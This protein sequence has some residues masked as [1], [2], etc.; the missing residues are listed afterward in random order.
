MQKICSS[1]EPTDTPVRC[2][3][4]YIG[5]VIREDGTVEVKMKCGCIIKVPKQRVSVVQERHV[6]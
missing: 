2:G 3:H 4:N 1:V 5:C 6:V